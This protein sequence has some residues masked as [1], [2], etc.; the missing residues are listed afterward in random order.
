MSAVTRHAIVIERR[1]HAPPQSSHGG[2]TR[3]PLARELH[4]PGA[5]RELAMPRLRAPSIPDTLSMRS[6]PH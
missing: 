4:R 6:K 2:H 1:L 5:R 3:G